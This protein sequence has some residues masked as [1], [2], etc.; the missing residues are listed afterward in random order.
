MNYTPTTTHANAMDTNV[1]ACERA[2]K[3]NYM[4]KGKGK[5]RSCKKAR[6]FIHRIWT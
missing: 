2:F 4:N 5:M 1:C 3:L 6:I